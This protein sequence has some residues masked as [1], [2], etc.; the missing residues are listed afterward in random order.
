MQNAVLCIVAHP[1]DESRLCGGILAQ[2][3][4]QGVAVHVLCLTRGEGGE[5]GEPPLAT[6]AT[7]GAV[8]EEEMVCAVQRLGG[9]SVTFL[10][11]VDP[12]VGENA[13]LHAPEHT[14]AMLAAQLANAMTQ[15][16]VAAVLTHGSNGEY[17]HPAHKLLYQMTLAAVMSLGENAPVMYSFAAS[18]PEHPHPR[19]ANEDDPAHVVVDVRPYLDGPV[20]AATLCHRT[21]HAL[22]VRRMS[23]DAGRAVNV[24]EVVQRLPFEAV[25]R[26]WPPVNAGDRPNDVM[27]GW[28][29]QGG[30]NE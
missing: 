22:F 14:P 18:Y 16:Q 9:R 10:D 17:G 1:D 20:L 28:L 21:Q 24:A 12:L 5:L 13:T 3:A 30:G 8:R 27:V 29:T 6:R 2:L 26:H 4:A 15:F 19:L 7:L 25:H 23:E 11:Y